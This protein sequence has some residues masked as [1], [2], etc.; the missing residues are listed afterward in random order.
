MESVDDIVA[1]LLQYEKFIEKD[2]ELFKDF[3][4]LGTVNTRYVKELSQKER[5]AL[6]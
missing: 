6:Y 3:V 1:N 5:T 2:D 4:G